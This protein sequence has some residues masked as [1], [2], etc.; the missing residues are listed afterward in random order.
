MTRW[1]IFNL[2]SLRSSWFWSGC[3][4]YHRLSLC[5][6]NETRAVFLFLSHSLCFASFPNFHT[7]S[8]FC[9]HKID[10]IIDSALKYAFAVFGI[11]HNLNKS[12]AYGRRM[13]SL[14]SSGLATTASRFTLLPWWRGR[15][16]GKKHSISQFY[17][18]FISFHFVYISC[19]CLCS[20]WICTFHIGMYWFRTH[21]H[22]ICGVVVVAAARPGTKFFSFYC[23]RLSVQHI[24]SMLSP[25]TGQFRSETLEPGS[26]LRMVQ[27]E[28]QW[29]ILTVTVA[30]TTV[31]ENRI[32]GI[33]EWAR[34][35]HTLTVSHSFTPANIT[36]KYFSR[37]EKKVDTRSRANE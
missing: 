15:G 26:S 20:R 6:C 22:T 17:H 4:I 14:T 37:E 33:E 21:T 8:E 3:S 10:A 2:Y 28:W 36:P 30:A 1:E 23:K 31:I 16:R 34:N 27:M 13:S 29:E 25:S 35:T 32:T 9:V 19:F 7:D 24:K 12:L 5:V 18:F 11:K